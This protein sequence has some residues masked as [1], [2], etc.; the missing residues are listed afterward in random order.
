MFVNKIFYLCLLLFSLTGN[1]QIGYTVFVMSRKEQGQKP[2]NIRDINRNIILDIYRNNTTVSAALLAQSIN[3]S[4]TTVMKINKELLDKKIIKKVGKGR[5]TDEGGKKPVLYSLIEN[6]KLILAFHIHYTKIEFRLFNLRCNCILNDETVISKNESFP[7]IVSA[8]KDLLD[9]QNLLRNSDNLY[10]ACMVAIHG[11]T[12]S[13]T[14]QCIH[15]TYFPAWEKE[16]NLIHTIKKICKLSCPIY[17]DNWIRMRAYGENRLGKAQ[18]RK[19]VVLIDAGQHGVTS[20]ILI[21]GK[22]FKGCHS[23][24]G[25]I[26][27]ICMDVHSSIPCACGNTGCFESLV[28][29]TRLL[30]RTKKENGKKFKTLLE[31]FS[32]ADSGDRT[33]KEA[34]DTVSPWFALAISTFIL[35][36]DPE[37]ILVEGD[38]AAG[39][40][41]FETSIKQQIKRFIL[42]RVNWKTDLIFNNCQSVDALTGAAILAMDLFFRV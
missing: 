36:F 16:H 42:P 23:L 6:S 8:M 17:I 7:A 18:G 9:G 40:N 41:Y 28:S 5:S 21:D 3:L 19:S 34:L 31:I 35:F 11:D 1:I 20:G 32:A 33:A 27:H 39:C 13:E 24:A 29:Y 10:L 26:G 14:G 38:F 37:M 2:K 22:V 12:D 15:S 25:E 4:K 30:S